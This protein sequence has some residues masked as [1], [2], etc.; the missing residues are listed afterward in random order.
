[1]TTRRILI[2]LAAIYTLAGMGALV[3]GFAIPWDDPLAAVYALLAGLPWTILWSELGVYAEESVAI[4][5][6]LVTGS[7]V[8]NVALLWWWALTRR[9]SPQE[10]P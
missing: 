5:I 8:L 10:T 2:G 1:M 9:R 7:I 3:I 6:A 4:N